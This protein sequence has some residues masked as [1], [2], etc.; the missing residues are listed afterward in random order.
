[1]KVKDI[2]NKKVEFIESDA[3]VLDV[4]ERLVDK[5]IRSLVVKPEKEGD[6]HGVVTIRDIVFKCLSKGLE[7]KHVKV[8]E[9]ATKPLI[10]VEKDMPV[11]HAIKL[12][13]KFNIARVFVKEEG[14]VIGI[15]ALMDVVAMFL[16]NK[17]R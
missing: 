5:R 14:R 9:I 6:V 1:M 3:S 13:E 10:Y 16:I 11:E 8:K 7:P 2:M 4:I 15:V 17:V 12:M